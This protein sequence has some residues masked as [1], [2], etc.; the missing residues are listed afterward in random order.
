MTTSASFFINESAGV[1][2]VIVLQFYRGLPSSTNLH[3]IH[4]DS[5]QVFTLTNVRILSAFKKAFTAH[6]EHILGSV[7]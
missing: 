2:G 6:L 4:Q 7:C 3:T 1:V 5:A